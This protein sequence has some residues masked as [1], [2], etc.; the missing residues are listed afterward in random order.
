LKR[1][2]M[3]AVFPHKKGDGFPA[4]Y[5][6]GTPSEFHELARAA[7]LRVVSEKRNYRSSYVT[8]FLPLYLLWRGVATVQYLID[9]D[10][11]ESFEMVL[12]KPAR[13]VAPE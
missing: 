5:Q 13:T 2:I 3:H 7:G 11:C 1:K 9:R 8:F 4:F 6:S 10:Y 12:H